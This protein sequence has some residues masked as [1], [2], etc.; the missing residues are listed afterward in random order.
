MEP[1][2]K[3][4]EELQILTSD[5]RDFCD[6]VFVNYT[7]FRSTVKVSNDFPAYELAKLYL[8]I[9]T[10][11]LPHSTHHGL[12]LNICKLYLNKCIDVF[13]NPTLDVCRQAKSILVKVLTTL[14]SKSASLKSLESEMS[15]N[16]RNLIGSKIMQAARF[17]LYIGN[18]SRVHEYMKF[19]D[20][21]FTDD[22]FNRVP[23]FADEFAE[24]VLLSRY[25]RVIQSQL[26]LQESL[27]YLDEDDY[28]QIEFGFK[29]TTIELRD[30]LKQWKRECSRLHESIG[31]QC[32]LRFVKADRWSHDQIASSR[33]NRVL[34]G[35]EVLVI[36]QNGRYWFGF[37]SRRNNEYAQIE[38]KDRLLLE[39][40]TNRKFTNSVSSNLIKRA[41]VVLHTINSA[42]YPT[43]IVNN[44]ILVLANKKDLTFYLYLCLVNNE[45]ELNSSRR[46][47]IVGD[48]V[49]PTKKNPQISQLWLLLYQV[50]SGELILP[51]RDL[52]RK[53][54]NEYRH[55]FYGALAS[56]LPTL[57]ADS[58]ETIY[59][60]LSVAY[61]LLGN[62][63][64][65]NEY[66]R[67]LVPSRI[68]VEDVAQAKNELLRHQITS[69]SG[70]TLPGDVFLNKTINEED[71]FDLVLPKINQIE[72][73]NKSLHPSL[74][75]MTFI[76]DQPLGKDN[77]FDLF[78]TIYDEKQTNAKSSFGR[79]ASKCFLIYSS[80]SKSWSIMFQLDD[81][82]FQGVLDNLSEMNAYRSELKN[83]LSLLVNLKRYSDFRDI[84]DEKSNSLRRITS[85]SSRCKHSFVQIERLMNTFA[86]KHILDIKNR[87]YSS[88][89]LM[90]DRTVDITR[91][92]DV[93][94]IEGVI[95]LKSAIKS[96]RLGYWVNVK[97]INDSLDNSQIQD[98]TTIH[99][100]ERDGEIIVHGRTKSGGEWLN[101]RM[102]NDGEFGEEVDLLNKSL[103]QNM[104]IGSRKRMFVSPTHNE[105]LYELIERT[106]GAD[107][108]HPETKSLSQDTFYALI[109]VGKEHYVALG[110]LREEEE[111][112]HYKIFLADPRNLLVN[113]VD[114]LETTSRD[115][116]Y[117]FDPNMSFIMCHPDDPTQPFQD[118]TLIR[119]YL[120]L[121]TMRT[122]RHIGDQTSWQFFLRYYSFQTIGSTRNVEAV[123]KWFVEFDK[124]SQNERK[125]ALSIDSSLLSSGDVVL[126]ILS[127]LDSKLER[128]KERLHLGE[129]SLRDLIIEAHE[130]ARFLNRSARFDI[131]NTI[132]FG[133]LNDVDVDWLSKSGKANEIF[134]K[135]KSRLSGLFD[136]IPEKLMVKLES[137]ID[138]VLEKS[139]VEFP[140]EIN[141][142]LSEMLID[143]RNDLI[144]QTVKEC[145]TELDR[146]LRDVFI[147]IV[148]SRANLNSKIDHDVQS[149]LLALKSF[150]EENEFKGAESFVDL[151]NLI[152]STDPNQLESNLKKLALLWPKFTVFEI[153]SARVQDNNFN[154]FLRNSYQSI[155]FKFGFYSSLSEPFHRFV[156]EFVAKVLT[157]YGKLEQLHDVYKLVYEDIECKLRACDDISNCSSIPAFDFIRPIVELASSYAKMF[158]IKFKDEK[159]DL[160]R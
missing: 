111:L 32:R 17:H 115:F 133:M 48:L 49:F 56:K 11:W 156:D 34:T 8:N 58:F 18:F 83:V 128:P 21:T 94:T 72:G 47:R 66:S 103:F 46:Y 121:V 73:L 119:A 100:I 131:N 129:R 113:Y 135:L 60:K 97:R 55:V 114:F 29:D 153:K 77:L 80:F 2:L 31:G 149:F 10:A 9:A 160:S 120:A 93:T 126:D 109:K 37:S 61:E 145:Q 7:S 33:R 86:Q 122:A 44:R 105:L 99:V 82:K 117:E 159:N 16:G 70:L 67:M 150:L 69:Q 13:D 137:E 76:T 41:N 152:Q 23:G 116:R 51:E 110:I 39:M 12:G 84:D 157:D 30:A 91:V 22:D 87:M 75:L 15:S 64:L 151:A 45:N 65:A 35:R 14:K 68:M 142:L 130:S 101:K 141:T 140:V 3:K 108:S 89:V 74:S 139:E 71:F 90:N 27:M 24:I 104:K 148:E 155:W 62:K 26:D 50:F 20:E 146:R 78:G 98:E 132:V 5:L 81:T 19:V 123:K 6:Q 40:L 138:L 96:V 25:G 92:Y 4:N 102:D 154:E 1:R 88:P 79:L 124:R 63:P 54:T 52:V 28:T 85:V 125:S 42:F 158:F 106:F 127:K 134:S 112:G 118:D 36:S 143:E 136:A 95:Q 57:R 43:P 147:Q 59:Q 38:I 53:L 144:E 107:N